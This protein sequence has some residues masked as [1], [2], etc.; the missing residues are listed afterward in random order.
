M[1]QNFNK[2]LTN[3]NSV[4]TQLIHDVNDSIY[5]QL[6]INKQNISIIN[7]EINENLDKVEVYLVQ[8]NDNITIHHKIITHKIE[9][10]NQSIYEYMGNMYRDIRVDTGVHIQNISHILRYFCCWAVLL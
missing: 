3:L 1:S 6:N 5:I 10:N 2:N 4:T 9:E 7:N 8:I